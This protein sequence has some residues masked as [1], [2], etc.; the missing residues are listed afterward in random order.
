MRYR[1]AAL[2][3]L[4]FALGATSDIVLI[5]NGL[6]YYGPTLLDRYAVLWPAWLGSIFIFTFLIESRR[7]AA[8]GENQF[9]YVSG[10]ALAIWL[11]VMVTHVILFIRDVAA[12]PTSH[13]LWPFEFLFWTIVVAVPAFGGSLLARATGRRN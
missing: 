5:R 9:R 11:G 1:P 6:S 8:G 12:D 4:A 7:R 2:A 13:N 3:L 10:P